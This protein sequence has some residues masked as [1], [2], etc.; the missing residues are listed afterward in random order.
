MPPPGKKTGKS[1]IAE[2]KERQRE[3]VSGPTG[4][5]GSVANT[6]SKDFGA[7]GE[8][9]PPPSSIMGTGS[10]TQTQEFRNFLK[11]TGRNERN[12]YGNEGSGIFGALSRKFPGLVTYDNILSPQQIA[13]QNRLAFDRYKNPFAERNILGKETGADMGAGRPRYGV[14]PGMRVQ[15]PDG[16]VVT[17]QAKPLSGIA[18]AAAA[19]PYLGGI[20]NFLAPKPAE[21]PGFEADNPMDTGANL[22]EDRQNILESAINKLRDTF[23]QPSSEVIP[24]QSVEE[25]VPYTFD[26]A[27][28]DSLYGPLAS[29][30]YTYTDG[31]AETGPGVPMDREAQGPTYRSPDGRIF[32]NQL[33]AIE[34]LD[35]NVT[36]TDPI[37][38]DL[39]TR[40]G[41]GGD[42]LRNVEMSG[43][44]QN[45]SAGGNQGA[46]FPVSQEATNKA[47]MQ[48]FRPLTAEELQARINENR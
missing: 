30:P 6:G 16:R 31:P 14:Q 38:S 33:E 17:A 32:R 37:V 9:R 45:I 46:V 29:T 36:A 47:F 12:P 22:G 7:G 26:R 35:S 18:G 48:A 19:I 39:L 3:V 20:I 11:D 25:S 23:S 13:L 44:I 40:P 42:L 34:S 27:Y 2:M 43:G 41:E 8:D 5:S 28:A 24:K 1:S 4:G 21:I 10:I 15:T